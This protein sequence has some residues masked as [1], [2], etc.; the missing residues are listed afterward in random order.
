M[1]FRRCKCQ[2]RH[3]G[4]ADAPNFEVF[5]RYQKVMDFYD[6]WICGDAL[7]KENFDPNFVSFGVKLEKL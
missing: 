7:N 6:F 4:Q 3:F 5:L 1:I 2:N